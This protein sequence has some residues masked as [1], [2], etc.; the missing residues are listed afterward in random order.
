MVA[1]VVKTPKP[2]EIRATFLLF[3]GYFFSMDA[4]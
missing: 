4:R 3:D 1:Q 2:V